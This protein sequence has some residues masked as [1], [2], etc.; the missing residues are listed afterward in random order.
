[1]KKV[2]MFLTMLFLFTG[3]GDK[4]LNTPTKKVE[5][6]FEKYQSLDQDVIDQLDNVTYNELS[7]TDKQR[8]EYKEI[9]KKHYQALKYKIKDEIIDGDTATVTTEI[10]V[11][12]YSKI[13]SDADNYLENNRE[14]FNDDNG[15][16]DET[17][18]NEY[19]LKQLKSADE[20]VTYTIDMTLTNI[21]GEWVL[22]DVSRDTSDKIQGIYKH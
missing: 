16:Y 2:I 18:F 7:F 3:C 5:M 15:N 10:E 6:F 21:D 4:M 14:E 8:E 19:R 13:L 1:M 22:D 17:L 9:M 12:D 20:T 11:T